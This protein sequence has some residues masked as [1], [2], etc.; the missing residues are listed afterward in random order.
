MPGCAAALVGWM[1][2]SAR[3]ARFG[4]ALTLRLPLAE[5]QAA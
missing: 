4:T 2:R 1:K 3:N 5:A